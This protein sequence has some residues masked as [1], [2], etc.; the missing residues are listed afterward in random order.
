MV[1]QRERPLGDVL[2][3]VADAFQVGVDLQCRGQK[4]QVASH[5]LVE[6]QQTRR[7]AVD[8]HLHAVDLRLVADH[9]L[10]QFLVLVHQ[11]TNAAVDGGLHQPAH[12]QQLVIQFFE[13]DGEMT[14]LSHPLSGTAGLILT[15]ARCFESTRI[16]R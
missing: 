5:R 11:G 13:F 1:H 10:G 14:H 15:S 8:F 2:G 4:A 9:L 7:Q 3:E 12:F 16:C 6:R